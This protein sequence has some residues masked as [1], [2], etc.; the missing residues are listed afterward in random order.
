MKIILSKKVDIGILTDLIR[1]ETV[2]LWFPVVEHFP[3]HLVW[4]EWVTYT[5]NWSTLGKWIKT[6]TTFH[7]ENKPE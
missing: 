1:K 7:G 4:W 2:F 3:T 6:S 5:Y